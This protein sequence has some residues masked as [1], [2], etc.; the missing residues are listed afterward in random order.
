M[1]WRLW[2]SFIAVRNFSLSV[3]LGKWPWSFSCYLRCRIANSSGPKFSTPRAM[4]RFAARF[5]FAFS[6]CARSLFL[7]QY[8]LYAQR[9]FN[10]WW[11][12]GHFF[13]GEETT[14]LS[15]CGWRRLRVRWRS[16]LGC[17]CTPKGERSGLLVALR[18][19]PRCSNRFSPRRVGNEIRCMFVLIRFALWVFGGLDAPNSP[20]LSYRGSRARAHWSL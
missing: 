9:A 11:W 17:P 5:F 14:M 7:P 6:A 13:S 1:L 12:F 15:T 16:E 10:W 18:G 20:T 3:T 4:F 8:P 19:L 2:R